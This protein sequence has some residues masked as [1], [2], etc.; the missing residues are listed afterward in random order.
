MEQN[1]NLSNLI[2]KEAN[3]SLIFYNKIIPET[4]LTVK[5]LIDKAS[6]IEKKLSNNKNNLDSSENELIHSN[7]KH[8]ETINNSYNNNNNNKN[9]Q[10]IEYDQFRKQNNFI[11]KIHIHRNKEKTIINKDD[12][13]YSF[14]NM[15]ANE[16]NTVFHPKNYSCIDDKNNNENVSN[17]NNNE[18]NNKINRN[19]TNYISNNPLFYTNRYIEYIYEDKGDNLYHEGDLI[20]NLFEKNVKRNSIDELYLAKQESVYLETYAK[21]LQKEKEEMEDENKENNINEQFNEETVLLNQDEIK[22]I[23]NFLNSKRE[24]NPEFAF[25]NDFL[26]KVLFL[27]RTDNSQNN[28]N[29]INTNIN[30]NYDESNNRL[31]KKPIDISFQINIQGEITKKIRGNSKKEHPRGMILRGPIATWYRLNNEYEVTKEKGYFDIRN[32]NFDNINND[33]FNNI[34]NNLVNNI[35]NNNNKTNNQQKNLSKSNTNNNENEEEF[36]VKKIIENGKENNKPTIFSSYRIIEFNNK[37]YRY[38]FNQVQ[39]YFKEFLINIENSNYSILKFLSDTKCT[40]LQIDINQSQNLIE[41]IYWH[42]NLITLSLPNSYIAKLK[43]V[44]NSDNW[45]CHLQTLTIIKDTATSNP[46]FEESIITLFSLKNSIS[47]QNI[48][49]IDISYNRKIIDA[50]FNHIATF[51]D[52]QLFIEGENEENVIAQDYNTNNN[53]NN[54]NNDNIDNNKIKSYSEYKN[55]SIPILNLSWKRTI[56]SNESSAKTEDAISLRALYYV[57]MDMLFHALKY[58]NNTVPEVFNMLDLSESVVTDDIGF[59]VKIITKFKIIKELNISNTKIIGNGKL[60]EHPGFLSKIK[61]TEKIDDIYDFEESKEQIHNIEKEIE[62]FKLNNNEK[63]RNINNTEI[64]F[65]DEDLFYNFSLGI[66]PILEKIYLYNTDVKE[67]ISKEIYSLF[68]RLKFF[69][70]FYYSSQINNNQEGNNINN[71]KLGERIVEEIQKD[72]KSYCENVFQL[73]ND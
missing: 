16:N 38:F 14:L 51:Y 67:D 41:Y 1:E 36:E 31:G 2:K 66:F 22:K 37:T 29:I 32:I 4:K 20:K 19:K 45:E 49:F 56:N 60:I 24:N 39:K 65:N 54:N 68:K 63:E 13:K 46:P 61:L 71:I 52:E 12:I 10:Y 47:I 50:L 34:N 57:F 30:S 18:E 25:K 48:H 6:E 28:N 59:L 69:Q 73:S 23:N 40:N 33:N 53:I 5:D 72:K 11:P 8:R 43:N 21:L 42:P 7:S 70:G 3:T 44:M 62:N 27:N 55:Q 58:N 9:N 64:I 26:T 35:K 15:F 17:I